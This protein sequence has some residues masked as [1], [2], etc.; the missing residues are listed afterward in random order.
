VAVLGNFTS[1]LGFTLVDGRNLSVAG[2]V[3]S[4]AGAVT[5]ADGGFAL[6]VPGAITGSS[7]TLTAASIGIGG[8]LSVTG[9]ASLAA[10]GAI[11]ETA[12]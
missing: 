1:P 3:A 4:S 2:L 7:G 11:T 12:C 10:T 6:T 8:S 5:I 9:T